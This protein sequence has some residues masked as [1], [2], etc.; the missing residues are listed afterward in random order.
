ML[1]FFNAL[2]LLKM[3]D[4]IFWPDR[5]TFEQIKIYLCRIYIYMYKNLISVFGEK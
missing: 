5:E 4:I 3:I 1:K 2:I